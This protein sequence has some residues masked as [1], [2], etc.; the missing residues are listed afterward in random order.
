MIVKIHYLSAREAK[1]AW[2]EPW[3]GKICWKEASNPL[4]ILAWKII[5]RQKDLVGYV[6]WGT[7]KLQ[8]FGMHI[9]IINK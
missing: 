5:C 8:T 3:V 2:V 7:Q 9:S 4:D 6:P 1:R